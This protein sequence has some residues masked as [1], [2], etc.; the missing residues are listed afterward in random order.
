MKS[1]GVAPRPNSPFA[2]HSPQPKPGSSPEHDI[3]SSFINAMRAKMCKRCPI[4]DKCYQTDEDVL[5]CLADM[6]GDVFERLDI[7][8]TIEIEVVE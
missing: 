3:L 7:K 2:T 8:P 6:L 4:H 5:L 1:R